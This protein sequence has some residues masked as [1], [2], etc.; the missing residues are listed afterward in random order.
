MASHA[1][2]MNSSKIRALKERHAALED[3]INEAM[4]SPGSSADFYLRQLKKQKLALKDT[5][6]SMI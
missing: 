5:I 1:L 6:E 2:D 3:R 4:K